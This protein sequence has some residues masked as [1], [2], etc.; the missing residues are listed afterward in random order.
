M[1]THRAT[2]AARLAEINLSLLSEQLKQNVVY[3]IIYVPIYII[4]IH[5]SVYVYC[6]I[7]VYTD[8]LCI[9]SQITCNTS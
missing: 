5:V 7:D 6:N 8:V 4:Y 1:G 9:F 2:Q 3:V